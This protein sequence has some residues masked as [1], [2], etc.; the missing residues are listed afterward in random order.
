MFNVDFSALMDMS[1][2]SVC[3]KNY[4]NG[5][6]RECKQTTPYHYYMKNFYLN[7]VKRKHPATL[8]NK[9]NQI[10]FSNIRIYS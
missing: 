3:I 1:F 10:V 9:S 6:K 8:I 7:V 5:K 4:D 2:S